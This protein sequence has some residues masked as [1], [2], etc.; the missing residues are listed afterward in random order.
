[1]VFE[2]ERR[3]T[4]FLPTNKLSHSPKRAMLIGLGTR[5]SV[6]SV[7]LE[8]AYM[9]IC[10]C[11][12]INVYMFIKIQKVELYIY[13]YN[14]KRDLTV[15]LCIVHAFMSRVHTI[16]CCDVRHVV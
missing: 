12:Y 11:T 10:A 5:L 14:T 13:M 16:L 2:V 7:L 6:P 8:Q 3:T 9:Y 15:F 4:I 1:M